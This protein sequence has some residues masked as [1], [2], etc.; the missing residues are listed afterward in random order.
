VLDVRTW[1]SS[2]CGLDHFLVAGRQSEIE[3]NKK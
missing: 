3:E 2:D 1:G